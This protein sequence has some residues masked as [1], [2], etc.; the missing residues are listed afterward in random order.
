[1][2]KEIK[3]NQEHFTPVPK[4]ILKEIKL[5][6]ELLIFYS[7][8]CR[9]QAMKNTKANETN[10]CFKVSEISSKLNL[11]HV[12]TKKYLDDLVE[13]GLVYHNSKDSKCSN[14]YQALF[15]NNNSKYE[16]G[17]WTKLIKRGEDLFEE[18]L[19]GSDV[20]EHL[21]AGYTLNREGGFTKVDD[22]ILF[23]KELTWNEKVWWC[24]FRIIDETYGEHGN[25]TYAYNSI[26][27]TFGLNMPKSDIK[28]KII[29]LS[30]HNLVKHFESSNKGIVVKLSETKIN[31]TAVIEKNKTVKEEVA[32]KALE[33]VKPVEEQ[34]EVKSVEE[35]SIEQ[36]VKDLE[37]QEEELNMVLGESKDLRKRIIVDIETEED[38]AHKENK[39]H[40]K[41]L[42]MQRIIDKET[43]EGRRRNMER[44][45]QI[46]KE[47]ELDF[48]EFMAQL[49]V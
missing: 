32:M 43:E 12:S 19:D 47:Q 2:S 1:M 27:T 45:E 13:I 33:E 38:K 24:I 8:I 10:N 31:N 44:L 34:V 25:G 21:I 11:N 20:S 48:D 42:D 15:Y 14:T 37:A 49:S 23:S 46:K 17:K 40:F 9:Y 41:E 30:E 5:K 7:Y 35:D 36:L 6:P 16:N 3:E 18:E 22:E 29:K 26:N 4:K 39:Q 28:N